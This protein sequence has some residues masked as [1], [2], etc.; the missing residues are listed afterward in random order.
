[1]VERIQLIGG[2]WTVKS[3]L[4]PILGYALQIEAPPLSQADSDRFGD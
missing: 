4:D 2:G 1:M 3:P